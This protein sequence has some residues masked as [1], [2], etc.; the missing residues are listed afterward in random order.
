[1][2]WATTLDMFMEIDL[3]LDSEQ[4]VRVDNILDNLDIDT[5]T[6]Q[7]MVDLLTITLAAKPVLNR[8]NALVSKIEERLKVI[9]PSRFERLLEGLK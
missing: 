8:R 6:V 7:E 5:A 4:Y 2:K 9:E 1:M 3:L